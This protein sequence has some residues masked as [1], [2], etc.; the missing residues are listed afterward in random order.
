MDN[1][2]ELI[3]IEIIRQY[4]SVRQFAF[5]VGIPL[6]TINSALIKGV[7][8]SSYDNVLNMC[9]ILGI[10]PVGDEH[11]L[12]ATEAAADLIEKYAHLD[13]YGR[14]T[15]DAVL[16]VEYER[17]KENDANKVPKRSVNQ[18]SSR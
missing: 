12:Y 13:S 5:A 8:G 18:H 16:A 10:R 3:R 14:H 1:L 17:C 4:R 7:G 2:T 9:K 6:S 11:C 15:V